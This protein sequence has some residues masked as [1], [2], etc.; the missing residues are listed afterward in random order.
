MA[1]TECSGE[2]IAE[3][4]NRLRAGG[5][6]RLSVKVVPKSSRSE[7]A[8]YME[9]GTLKIRIQAPPEKGKANSELCS[10]L[11]R[12]LEVT[13]RNVEIVSGHASPRK[14]VRVSA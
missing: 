3:L 6:L 1:R 13:P 4:R 8:G 9:D 14:Q 10:F 7:I 5:E 12:V 11:A 2:E